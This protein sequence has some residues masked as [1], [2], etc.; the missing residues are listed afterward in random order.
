MKNKQLAIWMRVVLALCGIAIF[1]VL[2]IPFW[3]I[4]LDAPQYPEGLKLLIYTNKIG[5]DVDIINGLNHYIGMK[6]LH[7]NDFAEFTVL[8]YLTAAFA[9]LFLACGIMGSR[10]LLRFTFAA[11]VLFGIIAMADFWRWEYDYG[12]D[13]NPD[14]AIKV[15]GMAYQPPLIGYKQL[16]NFGAYSVPHI[17]GWLFIIAGLLCGTVMVLDIRMQRMKI[18]VGKKNLK[19]V[20]PAI[21]IVLLALSVA[22]CNVQPE[23]LKPGQDNCYFC[24]MA[25]SDVRFGSELITSKGKIYKFDD[26]HCLLSYLKSNVLDKKEIKEVYLTDFAGTHEFIPASSAYLFNSESLRSPMN[27]NVA[28]FIN[29]K[30]MEKMRTEMNGK[31]INWSELYN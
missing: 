2:F 12:H 6:T 16:L 8:P 19:T 23:P 10:K 15:P 24:K 22:S 7:A 9:I 5:G 31:L 25:V 1:A 26:V 13:L 20:A 3:R 27:G 17:G 21:A 11:F 18:R 28:A 30:D 4:D 29:E 14:A